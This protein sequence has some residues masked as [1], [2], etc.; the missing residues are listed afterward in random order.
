MWFKDTPVKV[1]EN[2]KVTVLSDIPVH[3]DMVNWSEVQVRKCFIVEASVIT[4]NNKS[5]NKTEKES[6]YKDREMEVSR[7]WELKQ[8][9]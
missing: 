7:T 2:D 8:S 3:T 6:T 1:S 4:N 5:Q 9:L